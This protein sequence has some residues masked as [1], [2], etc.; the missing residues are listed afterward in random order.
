[1]APVKMSS[2]A[3][4]SPTRRGSTWVP[5]PPGMRPTRTSVWPI[6]TSSAAM[7]MSQEI[8]SSQPAPSARP[9]TQATT[10]LVMFRMSSNGRVMYFW[11]TT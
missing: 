11:D 8:I 1:M 4:F 9:L 6:L 2:L 3:F 7:M 5:P 10:G